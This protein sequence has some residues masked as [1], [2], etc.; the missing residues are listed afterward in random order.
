MLI[1]ATE[2]TIVVVLIRIF[3]N[4]KQIFL[5]SS[6]K[7]WISYRYVEILKCAL[8]YVPR[9]SHSQGSAFLPLCVTCFVVV[10]RAMSTCEPNHSKPFF[11][12]LFISSWEGFAL[13]STDD[14][15][16]ISVPISLL[17]QNLPL[18]V[19]RVSLCSLQIIALK[20][21]CKF[22]YCYKICPCLFWYIPILLIFLLKV[23]L[24]KCYLF[25]C[26]FMYLLICLYSPSY[27]SW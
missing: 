6:K 5:Y 10:V 21:A 11:A 13:F 9:S 27:L 23:I 8:I 2:N 14:R 19:E 12:V 3:L 26:L 22:H 18:L 25:I 16:E 15:F 20:L 1:Y 4:S 17:L 24:N 7:S